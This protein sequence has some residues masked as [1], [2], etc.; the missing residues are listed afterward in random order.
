MEPP[1]VALKMGLLMLGSI[2]VGQILLMIVVA[3]GHNT[4]SDGETITLPLAAGIGYGF[5]TALIY[6][7]H[8]GAMNEFILLMFLVYFILG[9]AV[10]EGF[11]RLAAPTARQALNE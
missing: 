4:T 2:I 7:F 6:L 10:S 11:F 5:T 9:T 8:G 1:D 3:R